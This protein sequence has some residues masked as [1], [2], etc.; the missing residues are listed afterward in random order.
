MNINQKAIDLLEKNEYE[1]ALMLFQKAVYES[2]NVQSLTNLA[3]VYC[4]EEYDD[5]KPLV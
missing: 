1:D 2:R 4:Y 3:C 5:T